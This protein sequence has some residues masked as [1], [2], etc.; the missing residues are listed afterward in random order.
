MTDLSLV[1]VLFTFTIGLVALL[2]VVESVGLSKLVRRCDAGEKT[3]WRNKILL[4]KAAVESRFEVTQARE[5]VQEACKEFKKELDRQMDDLRVWRKKPLDK[6]AP[7]M[8]RFF[9]T[10]LRATWRS[11]AS[12]TVVG[13]AGSGLLLTLVLIEIRSYELFR[14]DV[15]PYL[16]DFPVPAFLV[17][18]LQVMLLLGLLP[19]IFATIAVTVPSWAVLRLIR[20]VDGTRALVAKG[21]ASIYFSACDRWTQCSYLALPLLYDMSA[22]SAPSSGGTHARRRLVEP[23]IWFLRNGVRLIIKGRTSSKPKLTLVSMIVVGTLFLVVCY[24]AVKFE[25]LYRI[26][27]ICGEAKGAKNVRVVLDPPLPGGNRFTRIGSIGGNVFIVPESCESQTV[28]DEADTRNDDQRRGGA[29]QSEVEQEARGSTE[30]E[31]NGESTKR[32]RNSNETTW[33]GLQSIVDKIR[34]RVRFISSIG[35]PDYEKPQVD[36]AKV[37]VVPLG[38]VLCMYEVRDGQSNPLAA[39]RPLS[40]ANGAGL[41]I[42]V[43]RTTDNAWTIVLP[44]DVRMDD[45]W[46]LKGEIAQR[47]CKSGPTEISEP[48]L[49]ERGQTIPTNEQAAEAIIRAFLN[50]PES[51]NFKLHV[52]GFASG[53]GSSSHNKDLA[54][55]RA[56]AVAETARNLYRNRVLR[57]KSWGETHLTNGVAN[58]RSVRLVGCRPEAQDS[59]G[60]S[61]QRA[62]ATTSES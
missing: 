38:R 9:G 14:F 12:R 29:N 49:F 3:E 45:E 34:S 8:G 59:S 42:T 62:P 43:Q 33:A 46:R 50:T 51:E 21:I 47:L 30:T 27:F 52:L 54:W 1:M 35:S 16:L 10:L 56:K 20:T 24:T 17:G 60:S 23:V 5:N 7:A 61:G 58:S 4:L 32:D 41:R 25:P 39:C 6:A 11:I 55:E 48:I 22:D 31:T 28:D 2:I 44:P 40:Q 37:T 19:L 57:E 15:F 26:H 18:L 53:D 13:V 36:S